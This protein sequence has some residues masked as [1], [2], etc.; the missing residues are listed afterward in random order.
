MV[1]L[2]F[3]KVFVDKPGVNKDNVLFLIERIVNIE[4]PE[5]KHQVDAACNV[6]VKILF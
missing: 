3:G 5:E 4:S 1:L 6:N 2:R